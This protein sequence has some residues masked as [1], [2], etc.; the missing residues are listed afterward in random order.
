MIC[1]RCKSTVSFRK[2]VC[3]NCGEDL[4]LQKRIIGASNRYYNLALDKAKVRD[5]S[6]ALQFLKKSLQLNKKNTRA[7]NLQ[8]LIYYEM[9][10]SILAMCTW[11]LSEQY[12]DQNNEAT[13]YLDKLRNSP[14]K[15]ENL[16]QAAKKFNTA[17]SAAQMGNDDLAMIQ[18]KKVVSMQPNYV[19]AAQLL[20]LLYI[21]AGERDKASKLLYKLK[22][23][24]VNNTITLRYLNEIGAPAEQPV[25]AERTVQAASQTHDIFKE[26]DKLNSISSYKEVKP[27][28]LPWLNLF[29]GLLLGVV[30]TWYLI[31]PEVQ[32]YRETEEV[33]ELDKY[34]DQNE[35]QENT[36]NVL[37]NEIDDLKKKLDKAQGTI[38]EL[39]NREVFDPAMY[40]DLFQAI[41]LY[42]QGKTLEAAKN[43]LGLDQSILTSKSAKKM[44][45]YVKSK[46]FA[47]ASVQLY[48]QGWQEYTNRKYDEA[49][50]TLKTAV[51]FDSKNADALYF[52]G[53]TYDQLANTKKAKAYY[54]KVI[55]E[56]PN[57]SRASEA[58][59]R[60]NALNAQ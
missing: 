24:D 9:G 30:V 36:I 15:L 39:E 54:N 27:S 35:K 11:V 38:T 59:Q 46:T 22:K 3:E 14:T 28:P 48:Q 12:D 44:Y 1:P 56:F 41:S 17:L 13:G 25:K 42:H 18:L 51:E 10:E 19:K 33:S 57:T 6:G 21:R 43:L 2:D 32:K 37:E 50:K 55:K 31:V 52:L 16:N 58:T 26:T 23:I 45:N 40:D 29:L 8:G 53:R 4:R 47:D 5:L 60:L 7:R 20:A 34:V 49:K